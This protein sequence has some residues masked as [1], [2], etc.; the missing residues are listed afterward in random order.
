V[1]ARLRSRAL[2]SGSILCDGLSSRRILARERLVEARRS[3]WLVGREARE[4]RDDAET[5]T[6]CALCAWRFEGTA[7]AGRQAFAE[8]RAESHATSRH[9]VDSDLS[10]LTGRC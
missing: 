5:V 6:R 1:P 7:E 8:H 4:G 2:C 9:E 10:T 3:L